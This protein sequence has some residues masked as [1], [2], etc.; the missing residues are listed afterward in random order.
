MFQQPL[1]DVMLEDKYLQK[2]LLSVEVVVIRGEQ[3]VWAYDRK[4]VIQNG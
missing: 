1:V 2:G 3:N 4:S